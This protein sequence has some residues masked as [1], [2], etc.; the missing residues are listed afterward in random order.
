[1]LS[2]A[3]GLSVCISGACKQT[4]TIQTLLHNVFQSL[5]FGTWALTSLPTHDHDAVA[6]QT[7]SSKHI[8]ACVGAS[9]PVDYA[10]VMQGFYSLGH[11]EEAVLD[12]VPSLLPAP[13]ISQP[14]L[15]WQVIL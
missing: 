9:S 10:P 5:S 6:S 4:Q 3:C 8:H 1:M 7:C 2:A 11:A 13:T 14:F 15:H 12:I